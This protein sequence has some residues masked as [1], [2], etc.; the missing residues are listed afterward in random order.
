MALIAPLGVVFDMD[1]TLYLE[2]DYVRSGFRH[3]ARSFA[4]A[5]GVSAEALFDWLWTD[6]EAGGR[7]D[8]L[9]RLRAAFPG[10]Q[11]SVTTAE[12]VAAYREHAPSI[13]P[14][15]GVKALLD[16]LEQ[17]G[18]RLGLLSD[19]PL[20]CQRNKMAALELGDRFQPALLSDAWGR[21][22]WK[23]HERGYA[24]FAA[25]WG[26]APDRLIAIG[27][28]PE[29]DFVTPRRLGWLTIRVRLSGQL[30]AAL[31]PR[32]AEY[33]PHH[34]VFDLPSLERLLNDPIAVVST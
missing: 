24:Q 4:N 21:E 7:G 17:R 1:D 28:N 30:R 23:P 25:Q 5:A 14:L 18:V 11:E 27:D 13:T 29:K 12:M 32:S 22:Y 19:G 20:V 10:L 8:T 16:S 34:E 33:A 2:R 31:S 9:D 3:V 15:A 6:F 26:L